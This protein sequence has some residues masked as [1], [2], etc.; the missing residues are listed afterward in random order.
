MLPMQRH[1][2]YGT[3][4]GRR[5]PQASDHRK[6]AVSFFWCS[7]SGF[8]LKAKARSNPALYHV[9]VSFVLASDVLVLL[10][11]GCNRLPKHMHNLAGLG[12]L[13]PSL[14]ARLGQFQHAARSKFKVARSGKQH[15]DV[16]DAVASVA[17]PVPKGPSIA[18]LG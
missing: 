9:N 2:A 7:D 12:S 16:A 5:A 15:K 1:Q 14:S 3:L 18:R 4:V 6:E 8:R 11:S 10:N 13:I 17:A